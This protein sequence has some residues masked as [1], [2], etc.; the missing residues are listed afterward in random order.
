[1]EQPTYYKVLKDGQACHGGT[2]DYS[3]YLPKG[4]R[5]GKWLPAVERVIPCC[6]GYHACEDKSLVTWLY[7]GNEIWV[8]EFRETPLRNYDK[9]VGAQ[10]RFVRKV[11]HDETIGEVRILSRGNTEVSDGF[12]WAYDSATVRAYDSAT[13]RASGSATV[14][15]YDSATVRA[16]DSATVEAYDSATVEAYGSA[17]VLKPRWYATTGKVTCD[18]EA[19]LID[20]SQGGIKV[21]ASVPVDVI[22]QPKSEEASR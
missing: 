12:N 20:R 7:G 8:V 13:V 6:S 22:Q 17:T 1:M 16:Y 11:E 4:K 19:V 9:V 3:E 10:M 18:G 21:Y 5:P 2:F 15:A 14:R